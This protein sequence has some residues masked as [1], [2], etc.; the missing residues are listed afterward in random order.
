MGADKYEILGQ[1][2]TGAT[3]TVYLARDLS[4]DR[5]VAFKELAP[6]LATDPTFI[7]RFRGEARIMANLEHPNVVKVYDYFEEGGRVVL[8]SE[9]VRGASLRQ[10]LDNSGHLTPEQ[11]LG[12][13]KGALSGLAYAHGQGLVHRDI[14][15]ENLL[16]DAEGVSKLADFG[17]ALVASGPGAAG[18]MPAGSPAYMSPEMIAGSRVDLRTDIYSL[19]AALFEFL[20]GRAP[21]TGDN[22]LAVMRKHLH[23]PVP[24]PRTLNS[25]LPEEVGALVEKAMAKDA[26]DRQRTAEQFLDELEAAAVAGYGEDWE[27]RSS[28]KRLVEATAAALGLLLIGAAGAAAAGEGAIGEATVGSGASG[29]NK[30]LIAAGIAGLLLVGGIV[31][32][33]ASGAFGGHSSGGSPVAVGSPSPSPS[34]SSSP[35]PTDTSSPTPDVS[36]SPSPSPSPSLSP[37]ASPSATTAPTPTPTRTVQSP[38]SAPSPPPPTTV[39]TLSNPNIFYES[40]GTGNNHT[41][42]QAPPNSG[43]ACYASN[44]PCTASNV[45]NFALVMES[46]DYRYSATSNRPITVTV[47]WTSSSPGTTT[48]DP[49]SYSYSL[50]VKASGTHAANSSDGVNYTIVVGQTSNA[51]FSITYTDDAGPHTVAGPTFYF[52]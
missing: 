26:E 21:Y 4:L 40:C 17:Q 27:K 18:G 7:E 16:A 37:S 50:P 38:T 3:G 13:L 49:T 43:S 15:P 20:T 51:H 6:A 33:F 28:I 8:V 5:E 24:N 12:V 32:G 36:P 31:F 52:N 14:K 2:G 34:S 10:V 11:S 46:F 1:L 39:L 44:K 42:C 47:N 23:D 48:T 30:W 25:A 22:P 9:F 19:G 45:G 35:S 29:P 41:N